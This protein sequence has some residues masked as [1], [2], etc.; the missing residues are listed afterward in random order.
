M[1]G[2]RLRRRITIQQKTT[3]QDPYGQPVES[4]ATWKTLWAAVEPLRG[5]EY[6]RGQAQ[7]A[8][9][10]TRVRIRFVSGIDQETMRVV[11]GSEVFDIE[12]VI[13]VLEMRK[14][15]QLMCRR[16]V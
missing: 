12:G 6:M 14:E 1:Q 2:G 9:V 16:Q 5:T 15:I 3:T 4:W 8:S 10:D 13:H 7:E 11:H